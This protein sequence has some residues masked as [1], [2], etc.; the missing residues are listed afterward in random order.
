MPVQ[1][2]KS[3][4][5][6]ALT[7]VIRNS[8]EAMPAGGTLKLRTHVRPGDDSGA[9]VFVRIS[10]TGTGMDDETRKRCLEPFFSTKDRQ[11]AKG[12]GLSLVFGVMQRH[13]GQIEIE[14]RLGH[15]T[16]ITLEFPADKSAASNRNLP[17]PRRE[18]QIKL[19]VLCVDDEPSVLDVLEI[20]LSSQGHRVAAVGESR[21]AL[22]V[23]RAAGATRDPF[24]VVVTDL[25]M[26]R[27]DGRALAKTIKEESP[28]TPIV[29]LTGW[30]DIMK[31]EE[32]HPECVDAVLGKP[33]AAEE[34]FATLQ[35]LAAG[36]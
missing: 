26:P 25:A 8:L 5:R 24:D 12:L 4:L 35:N 10:D 18:A 1:G 30:G 31:V 19:R 9:R 11:G 2:N 13:S 27:M 22:E 14:T 7:H 15:G 33:P 20:I 6:E 23:F 29:M 32:N 34:L 3:E 28:R 17:V 16:D 21:R 36:S